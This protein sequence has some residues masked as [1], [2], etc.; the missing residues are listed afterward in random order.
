MALAQLVSS[1]IALVVGL[2]SL[3]ASVGVIRLSP[4]GHERIRILIEEAQAPGLSEDE[5]TT[6]NDELHSLIWWEYARRRY[7][8]DSSIL[9]PLLA[10]SS[11]AVGF[12]VTSLFIDTTG[13]LLAIGAPTLTLVIICTFWIIFRVLRIER[14]YTRRKLCELTKGRSIEQLKTPSFSAAARTFLGRII[15]RQQRHKMTQSPLLEILHD[16]AVRAD[17]DSTASLPGSDDID[18]WVD[19]GRTME[20]SHINAAVREYAQYS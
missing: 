8:S 13:Q 7:P 2:L 3:A 20:A 9:P 6:L 14:E 16:A 1:Y 17:P 10:V 5:K 11:L 18:A 4:Q 12:L 15:G 19:L